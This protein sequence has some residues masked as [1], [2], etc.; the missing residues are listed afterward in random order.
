MIAQAVQ[1]DIQRKIS[2]FESMGGG[3]VQI[4][5]LAHATTQPKHMI[6]RVHCVIVTCFPITYSMVK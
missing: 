4:Q 3:Q 6:I 5:I 1:S 2:V